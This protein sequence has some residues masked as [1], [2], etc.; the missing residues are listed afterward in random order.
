MDLIFTDDAIR[1]IAHYA[2]KLNQTLDNIGARRLRA[3]IARIVEN[4]SF[5][6]PEMRDETFTIDPDYVQKQL[7]PIVLDEDLFFF[8]VFFFFVN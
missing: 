8:G 7:G 3:V 4:L 1:S 6:A 5:N 2:R